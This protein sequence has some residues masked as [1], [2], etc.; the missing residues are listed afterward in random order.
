MQTTLN[1]K[2]TLLIIKTEIYRLIKST[3]EVSNLASQVD[4]S[5]FQK[6]SREVMKITGDEKSP[7]A[8]KDNITLLD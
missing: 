4:R 1:C 2:A 6:Y 8:D 5:D 3:Q 7:L